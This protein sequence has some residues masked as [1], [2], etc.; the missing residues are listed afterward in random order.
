MP[1]QIL[2]ICSCCDWGGS[3]HLDRWG[4]K[5][6]HILLPSHVCTE[7]NMLEFKLWTLNRKPHNHPAK[8]LL[9]V[10]FLSFTLFFSGVLTFPWCIYLWVFVKVIHGFFEVKF[11]WTVGKAWTQRLTLGRFASVFSLVTKSQPLGISSD[12]FAGFFVFS[13]CLVF[14]QFWFQNFTWL[15]PMPDLLE[16]CCKFCPGLWLS[17]L[18]AN[19]HRP[20]NKIW[21]MGAMAGAWSIYTRDWLLSVWRIPDRRS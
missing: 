14:F 5:S 11:Y 19:V 1:F 21:G 10:F 13:V 3:G 7:N 2:I 9:V 6:A 20:K 15:P 17:E 8:W 12:F 16:Y 4:R 18:K